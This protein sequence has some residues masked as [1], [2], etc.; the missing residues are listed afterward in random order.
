MDRM[1]QQANVR[2]VWHHRRAGLS[3]GHEK[4]AVIKSQ[5][6]GLFVRPMAVDTVP[7]QKRSNLGFKKNLFV[8][9]A[10]FQGPL[11]G[12]NFVLTLGTGDMAKES[13]HGE[14]QPKVS[15]QKQEGGRWEHIGIQNQAIRRGSVGLSLRLDR[16]QGE[17][18]PATWSRSWFPGTASSRLRPVRDPNQTS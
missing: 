6:T 2:L 18:S 5:A 7:M 12:R 14:A 1:D 17:T 8:G 9:R 15:A 10:R 16:V 13:Q 11:Y 4:P 3:A